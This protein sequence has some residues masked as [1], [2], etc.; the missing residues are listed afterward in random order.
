[1]VWQGV[2]IHGAIRDSAEIAKLP[3][4]CKA[5]GTMPRKS[6]KKTPGE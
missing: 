4:G 2:I 6:E 1:M 3:L 5:L